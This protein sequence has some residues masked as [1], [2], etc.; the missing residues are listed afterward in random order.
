M[1]NFL[2]KVGGSE[3]LAHVPGPPEQTL[4]NQFVSVC[5]CGKSGKAGSNP[6]AA[7]T[8]TREHAELANYQESE[9][10]AGQRYA[11]RIN[12]PFPEATARV[13][14]ER[15]ASGT[16]ARRVLPVRPVL[17]S[18]PGQEPAA[19]PGARPAPSRLRERP[20]APSGSKA[21]GCGCGELCKG[22]F[23]PGHDA[24]L[25]GRLGTEV[26]ERKITVQE[27]LVILEAWPKL[28]AKLAGRMAS[29]GVH[30]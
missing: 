4:G 27:A 23:R 29:A 24:K 18:S 13:L 15:L 8:A 17:G 28:H 3:G 9:E 1:S 2:I 6:S 5:R 25:L 26:R 21:C 10:E 12:A 11:D 20:P 30:I 22:T 16:L 7:Y 14:A 19:G